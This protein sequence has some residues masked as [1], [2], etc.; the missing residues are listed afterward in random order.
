MEGGNDCLAP[1][2]MPLFSRD[3]VDSP[4]LAGFMSRLDFLLKD[5]TEG[6]GLLQKLLGEVLWSELCCINHHSLCMVETGRDNGRVW[7]GAEQFFESRLWRRWEI[8]VYPLLLWTSSSFVRMH[9]QHTRAYRASRYLW[10][11]TEEGQDLIQWANGFGRA[12]ESSLPG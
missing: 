12:G 4:S 1:S 7:A 9:S 3:A 6:M 10:A 5:S 8:H 11:H 2:F